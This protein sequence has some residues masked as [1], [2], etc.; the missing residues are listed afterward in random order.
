MP[1][2]TRRPFH[3][4]KHW[5]FWP[6]KGSRGPFMPWDQYFRPYLQ[7]WPTFWHLRLK[8][9]NF[10]MTFDLI[11]FSKVKRVRW[12]YYCVPLRCCHHFAYNTNL[13]RFCE[14]KPGCSSLELFI[15]SMPGFT[16]L[17]R[18]GRT[19]SSLPSSCNLSVVWDSS[20]PLLPL[21][22]RASSEPDSSEDKSFSLSLSQPS[23]NEIPFKL[24]SHLKWIILR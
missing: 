18:S 14:L 3:F 2:E 23:K 6:P 13:R 5:I 10:W 1:P 22:V 8:T 12:G 20:V 21:V 15:S 19:S 16:G 4:I 9:C 7:Y 11:F 24:V 17:L